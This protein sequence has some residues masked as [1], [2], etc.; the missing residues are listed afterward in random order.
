MR[1]S[2]ASSTPSA[3]R[4]IETMDDKI[5]KPAEAK[6]QRQSS[7]GASVTHGCTRFA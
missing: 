6:S 7:S 1:K 3:E 2:A 5:I 4:L